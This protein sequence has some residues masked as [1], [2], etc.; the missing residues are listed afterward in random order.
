MTI[1]AHL[2]PGPLDLPILEAVSL[3]HLHGYAVLLR[4]EQI[5]RGALVIRRGEV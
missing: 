2:L 4:I 5:C 3:D 1:Q